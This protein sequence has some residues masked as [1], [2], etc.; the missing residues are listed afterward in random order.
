M[1][2][3]GP[4]LHYKPDCRQILLRPPYLPLSFVAAT[5]SFPLGLACRFVGEIEGNR[6]GKQKWRTLRLR[7]RKN[8]S[9][10]HTR[11]PCAS[12]SLFDL[13]CLT[14]S[15]GNRSTRAPSRPMARWSPMEAVTPRPASSTPQQE[16]S[17]TLP[18]TIVMCA[19]RLVGGEC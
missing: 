16:M 7:L 14:R 1:A 19:H 9:S 11:K 15:M 3:L 5:D 8:E 12:R 4:P 2:D 10:S 17:S 6:R 18:R 13:V